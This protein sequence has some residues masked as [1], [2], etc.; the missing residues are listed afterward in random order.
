MQSVR[1][2]DSEEGFSLIEL[3]VT[4]LVMAVVMTIAGTVLF[5]LS[6]SASRTDTMVSSEQTASIVLNQMAR[7]I[8][9][10]HSLSI[11]TGAT[12]NLE[13]ELQ[14]NKPSGGTANVEWIYDPVGK[15]VTRY[16]QNSGGTFVPSGPRATNVT[17]G[18]GTGIFTYYYYSGAP[19]TSNY[20]GCTS[21]IGVTLDIGSNVTGVPTFIENE[22]VAL[23]DQLAALT[24]PGSGQC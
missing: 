18:A 16:V 15:T 21:R 2:Q 8:R 22:D 13:V 3:L 1:S 7:D 5:S 23:T 9:S 12:A 6:R 17:N 4:V 19:I 11:P 20:S 24:A 10:S 14:V